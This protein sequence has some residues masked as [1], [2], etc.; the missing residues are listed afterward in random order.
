MPGRDPDP[1]DRDG[2][3]RRGEGRDLAHHAGAP[4]SEAPRRRPPTR[5]ALAR[6]DEV[7]A[8]LE[9]PLPID[10]RSDPT[11]IA[12]RAAGLEHDARRN[13]RRWSRGPRTTSAP[14]TSSRWC[15]PSASS[16]AFPLPAF[17][18]YRSL[19][20]GQPGA[21]PLLS[22]LRGFPDRL[23]RRRRS[24]CGSATARSRSAPSPAPARAA[25]RPPR[26]GPTRKA[27]SPT[28]RS[29]PST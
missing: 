9:R 27:C 17:A 23:L 3:V 6:L 7:T 24:W 20:A 4:A 1:P 29:A 28:R 11:Q 16:R 25:R 10:D 12:F 14:A 26:T 5:R 22:R 13:S 18:L 21:L 8:A 2:G 15:C 19:A